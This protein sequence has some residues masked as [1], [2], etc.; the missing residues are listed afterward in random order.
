M[1]GR[2]WGSRRNNETCTGV[3][4]PLASKGTVSV[5]VLGT[6]G[7]TLPKKQKQA[8][9]GSVASRGSSE[10]GHPRRHLEVISQS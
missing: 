7:A 4:C 3:N 1:A 9:R 10:A 6:G 8:Q 5:C 2:V